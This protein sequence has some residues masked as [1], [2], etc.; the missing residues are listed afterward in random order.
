MNNRRVSFDALGSSDPDGDLVARYDWDFGDGTTAPNGGAQLTRRYGKG[1][2]HPA[3]TLTVA[4]PDGCSTAFVSAYHALLQR[5]GRGDRDDEAVRAD[6]LGAR[7]SV[8]RG[9]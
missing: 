9:S 7:S 1:S 5:L 2:K 3:V 4:D 6:V 8:R